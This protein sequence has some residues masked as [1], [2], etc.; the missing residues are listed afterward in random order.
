MPKRKI[1]LFNM[2]SLDGYF[3]GPQGE[4]DWHRVD[5]EFNEFAVE[6]LR[7]ISTLVFGRKTYEMMA[8][9]WP[10]LQARKD[11]PLVAQAMNQTPKIV[12]SKTLGAATWQE[13]RLVQERVEET[14]GRL[15]EEAGKDLILLGSVQLASSLDQA[16]LLDEIRIIIAPLLL[17]Q[18]RPHFSGFSFSRPL[19]LLG[20]RSFRNG[21]VLLTYAR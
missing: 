11:D 5:A 7:G 12:V 10:S 8:A 3:S 19:N 16:G 9:Y 14:F 6:Q 15:R 13:S 2:C 1:V 21:N 20:T 18:G 4:L 17:G